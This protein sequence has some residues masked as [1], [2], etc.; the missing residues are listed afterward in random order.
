MF[1]RAVSIFLLAISLISAGLGQEKKD[2]EPTQN[3]ARAC[4]LA[5]RS[6]ILREDYPASLETSA[7]LAI[8]SIRLKRTL[9]NDQ[10][11]RAAS[12][13]LTKPTFTLPSTELTRVLLFS[14]DGKLIV[15]GGPNGNVRLLDA[16]NGNEL[17]TWPF[18]SGILALDISRDDHYL[19]V[20]TADGLAQIIDI[21]TRGYVTRF[22]HGAA[23]NAIIFSPNGLR[24]IAGS[25]DQ[26]VTI[27][28][29][30]NAKRNFLQIPQEGKVTVVA[31]SPDGSAAAAGT[32]SGTASMFDATTGKPSVALFHGGKINAI[33]FNRE[34]IAIASE[35]HSLRVFNRLSQ[36]EL[37]HVIHQDAVKSVSFNPDGNFLVTASSDYTARV[38]DARTGEELFRLSHKAGVNA[39]S[40][41]PNG[42][43][44]AT[45]SSDHTARVFEWRT[46][47]EIA[48]FP[49]GTPVN[50]VS[51]SP[52]GKS[53]IA[54]ASDGRVRV[55]PVLDREELRRIQSE[56]TVRSADLSPNFKMIATG[57]Y[58]NKIRVFG[59]DGAA[60]WTKPAQGLVSAISFSPNNSLL[61]TGDAHSARVFDADT[62]R[63]RR[64]VTHQNAVLSIAF[65]S[66]SELVATGMFGN[67]NIFV[68]VFRA[69]LSG[70]DI[71]L[72]LRHEEPVGAV[73]FSTTGDLLA[74]GS[75]DSTAR[76]FEL[77]SG[78]ERILS[79][80]V[81]E[82]A[83]N[84]VVFSKYGQWLATA[85]DDHSAR[86]FDTTTGNELLLLPHTAAVVGLA[87]S[88][89]GHWLATATQDGFVRVFDPMTGTQIAEINNGLPEI[90]VIRFSEDDRM[91]GVLAFG[92]DF[93][94]ARQYLFDAQAMIDQACSRLA[95]NLTE[96]EWSQYFPDQPYRKTCPSL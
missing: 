50:A 37:V 60:K 48:R 16:S 52:D 95:R 96:Y 53:L 88:H 28:D 51:F 49:F 23:V 12:N 79:P 74:T 24:V 54:A 38:L 55:Y 94:S 17:Y 91:L 19:A 81:H 25:D 66:D 64:P 92:R 85:S 39:A 7:L 45:A 61:A 43:W 42:Q 5:R 6:N 67:E 78:R 41:S 87:V 58:D 82:E 57:S 21:P 70:P 47:R 75:F 4:E 65:S 80:M 33:I 13:L 71:M 30:T 68:R 59:I 31:F 15:A 62:G 1:R 46:A 63:L 26:S 14:H 34:L 86:I 20:G 2:T 3:A 72:P 9:D 90:K 35:D 18:R 73:A 76:I 11:L 44:V 27:F 29:R 8:E 89:D 36:K 93:V 22:Q 40:F 32:A 77:P 56:A 83:V 69:I 10:A 84:A